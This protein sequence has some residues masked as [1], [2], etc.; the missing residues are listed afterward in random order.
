MEAFNDKEN[1]KPSLIWKQHL[2]PQ[3]AV[4]ESTS[5]HTAAGVCKK[6][7]SRNKGIQDLNCSHAGSCSNLQLPR[8]VFGD[9][10][11][12]NYAAGCQS[13]QLAFGFRPY[14]KQ[15]Q[16][17]SNIIKIENEIVSMPLT[18]VKAQEP[19]SSFFSE[20]QSKTQPSTNQCEPDSSSSQKYQGMSMRS[21]RSFNRQRKK[22][23]QSLNS[24]Q[25]SLEDNK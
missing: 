2:L 19:T 13:S 12:G 20:N 18:K 8:K 6:Q 1:Y 14:K 3:T 21:M 16:E 17:Q 15:K 24:S 23:E 4:E 22:Q 10:S 5:G 7:Q 25:E 9:I 11:E